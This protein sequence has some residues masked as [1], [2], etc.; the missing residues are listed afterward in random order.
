MS[1]PLYDIQGVPIKVGSLVA[2]PKV[3]TNGVINK[4]V[5]VRS[6]VSALSHDRV[7]CL[8]VDGLLIMSGSADAGDVVVLEEPVW[9]NS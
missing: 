7:Y 8:S 6:R 3:V 2:Y 9:P 5:L 1:K 4:V